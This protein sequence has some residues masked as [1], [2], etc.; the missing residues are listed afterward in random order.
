MN[1][2]EK[3]KELVKAIFRAIY[4]TVNYLEDC[5]G[6]VGT[7]LVQDK[8]ESTEVYNGKPLMPNSNIPSKPTFSDRMSKK[9][10]KK[11]KSKNQLPF[12]S[13]NRSRWTATFS[14]ML[15]E[16]GRGKKRIR[17][18]LEWYIGHY[19]LKYI[20]EARCANTFRK[21][22]CQIEA[23]MNRWNAALKGKKS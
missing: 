4:L 11:V 22:F 7:D 17:K 21:K 19:G 20:P 23:A 5:C 18:V 1:E 9:L 6:G 12:N 16:D 15:K 13:K 8:S 2:R 3:E 10:Y 14:S